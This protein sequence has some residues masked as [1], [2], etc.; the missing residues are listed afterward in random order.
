MNLIKH[1]IN[2]LFILFIPYVIVFFFYLVTLCSF[3]YTEAVTANGFILVYGIY[4]LAIAL[5]MYLIDSD[6]NTF[7]LLKTN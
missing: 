6:G 7:K 1:L 5:P 4:A 3:V 2:I